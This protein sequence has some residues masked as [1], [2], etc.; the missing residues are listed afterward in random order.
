MRIATIDIGT[1]SVLL[2]IAEQNEAGEFIALHEDARITRIGQGLGENHAFLPEA[3]DRTLTVLKD[4]VAKCQ[5]FEVSQIIA[6]GTA[7]F[8]R[9]FNAKDFVAQAKDQL[10]LPIEIISGEREAELSYL[11]AQRD[12]G[13][14]LLVIDIGG[15]S[16]EFIWP[17][18]GAGTKTLSLPLGS[19][20]LH[21]RLVHSD[22]ISDGDYVAVQSYIMTELLTLQSS[23]WGGS[24]APM[25]QMRPPKLVALAGTATTLA[26]M[27]LKLETYS[28]AD[29]HGTVLSYA[30]LSDQVQ[31]LRDA[32][33]AEKKQIPGIEP[34]RADV[35]L[36]GAVL[37][38][39][40]MKL[41]D[42]DEVTI[43][44]RGVRW[45]LIYELVPQANL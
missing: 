34:A 36:E 35:V 13:D 23:S 28:H 39:E 41:F 44:D 19:V 11:A 29:V 33:V 27:K 2:T 1:N 14:E 10:G 37:L 22:P 31:Q 15:G 7:A 43:S 30:E 38:H 5:K 45:G 32:T 6:V 42:Y 3:M 24:A 9:A 17:E 21:E 4:Y 20:V 16:T 18:S 8:R 40:A 26:A 25:L 12:F